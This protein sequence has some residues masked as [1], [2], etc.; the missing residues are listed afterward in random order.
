LDKIGINDWNNKID[1]DANYSEFQKIDL[2]NNRLLLN[3]DETVKVTRKSIIPSFPWNY[4]FTDISYCEYRLYYALD[5]IM[6]RW[7]NDPSLSSQTMKDPRGKPIE[8][9][10]DYRVWEMAEL[11]YTF[12]Y[13][14]FADIQSMRIHFESFDY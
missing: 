7:I 4:Q 9:L 8:E 6:N 5:R 3:N 1:N 10:G 13:R 12:T 2:S 11:Y 14:A